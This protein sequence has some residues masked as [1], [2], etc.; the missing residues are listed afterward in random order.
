MAFMNVFDTVE[1]EEINKEE[2]EDI[3]SLEEIND[4]ISEDFGVRI[5][6]EEK[7]RYY[8][9]LY[10]KGDCLK[11]TPI[12]ELSKFLDGKVYEVIYKLD[13]YNESVDKTF[14]DM[15]D[16]KMNVNELS[17]SIISLSRNLYDLTKEIY[18]LSDSPEYKD[19]MHTMSSS[20]Y[21]I[22]GLMEV[23]NVD[24]NKYYKQLCCGVVTKDELTYITIRQL[25]MEHYYGSYNYDVSPNDK[26]KYD[27]VNK[28]KYLMYFAGVE[29]FEEPI[30]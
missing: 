3:P 13:V 29:G 9:L 19:I 10:N 22:N 16:G 1:T 11:Y 7:D 27:F 30:E 21:C 26:Y 5:R 8:H 4:V 18:D 6:E 20:M 24:L 14:I 2:T 28:F 12:E 15:V 25:C 23:G 17:D